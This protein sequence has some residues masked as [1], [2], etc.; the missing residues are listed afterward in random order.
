M[1]WGGIVKMSCVRTGIPTTWI[2]K[3]RIDTEKRQL[4]FLH[5]KAALN[6]TRG[7]EVVWNFEELPQGEVRVSIT[8]ELN[9]GWPIIGKPISELI[10]GWFFIH[11][12]AGKTLAG[13]KRKL[14]SQAA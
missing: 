3:Y 1:P 9:L 10:V 2:S 14:E 12:I 13:L 8:H 11:Y 6:A 7:M 5:L 4:Q